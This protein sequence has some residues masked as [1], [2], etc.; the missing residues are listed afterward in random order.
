[1]LLNTGKIGESDIDE[2]YI[3]VL[4]ELEY[5]FRVLEHLRSS[6][7]WGVAGWVRPRC[8]CNCYKRRTAPLLNSV[9]NVSGMLH[10]L[11][12]S[13][14]ARVRPGGGRLEEW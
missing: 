4:D 14:D 3:F 5:F 11:R 10:T 2:L 6:A 7:M 8:M 1:M 9:R 12:V 13:P